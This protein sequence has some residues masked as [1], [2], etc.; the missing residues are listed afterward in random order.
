MAKVELLKYSLVILII[1][2][3]NKITKA[4]LI[5]FTED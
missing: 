2:S 3:Y 1:P 5:I 4:L